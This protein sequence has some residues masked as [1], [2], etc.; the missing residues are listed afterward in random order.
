MRFTLLSLFL[1]LSVSAFCQVIDQV[2]DTLI[3]KNEQR[4]EK[5]AQTVQQGSEHNLTADEV[6]QDKLVTL[7]LQNPQF[8]IDDANVRIAEYTRRKA[9]SSWLS[10]VA[11]GTNINEFVIAN[12]P[13]ANFYPKYN[14]GLSI[15][16][17]IFSKVGNDTKI[18]RQSKIIAQSIKLLNQSEIRLKVLTLYEDFKEK[19]ELVTLQKLSVENNL[20]DYQAAQK[21]FENNRIAIDQMNQVYQRYMSERFKLVTI[22]RDRRVAVFSLEEAIGMSLEKAVPGILTQ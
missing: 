3:K 18:A 7:A 19:S 14:I 11:V 8:A 22:K 13:V 1:L 5:V 9:A 2:P 21:D 17:D 15:P 10:I 4:K 12:S 16:F 20:A 6:I